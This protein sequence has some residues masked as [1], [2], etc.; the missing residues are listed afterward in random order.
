MRV[1][2]TGGAGYIG[3][4]VVKTL[5]RSGYEVT[6]LDNLVRG[7]KAVAKVLKEAEFVWGDIADRELV[8]GILRSRRIDAVMHFAA[9][10]L[11]GESVENPTLYYENN[12]IKGL[13]LLDSIREADIAYFIF[14]SSAAVYGE[15]LQVPIEEDHVL[16]PTNPYGATKRAFEEALKWYDSAYGLK[17]M[18]LRYFNAVGADPEG[19]L[20]EDHRPETHLV[21]LIL[22]AAMGKREKIIVYGADYPTPDGTCIRDYVHVCD[23]ASAHVLALEA[24]TRGQSSAVYNLGSERGLSVWE[25]IQ[26]ARKVTGRNIPVEIGPRRP[27]DPA[28]LVASAKKAKEFLGWKPCFTDIEGIISTAWEWYCRHPEGYDGK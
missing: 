17:Y 14:S 3:S 2:V 1:L 18:S 27:G 15:P 25:I 16:L 22:Q 5:L 7:H 6:V 13:M 10:S 26:A 28:V 20:G 12:V 4:H 11:V 21:P 19:D 23:L 24:L 8:T 9:L